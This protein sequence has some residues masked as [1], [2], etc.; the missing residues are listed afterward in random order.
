M[1]TYFAPAKRTE[2]RELKNQIADLSHNPIINALLK[3]TSGLL[4]VLNQDRQIV[5][6]NHAYIEKFGIKDIQEA[7]GLRLGESLACIHAFKKPDGCGTTEYC[8][9]CGAAIAIMSAFQDNITTEQICALVSDKGGTESDICLQVKAEPI[10]LEGQ[11]WLLFYAQDITQQQF[12]V[13]LDRVFFHDINNTLTALYGNVQLFEIGAPD[14]L[15]IISI[16]KS[17]ERL[18][19]EVAIQKNFSQHKDYSY[20]SVPTAVSLYDIKRELGLI[21]SGHSAS[22]H[23]KIIQHWTDK[24]LILETDSLLLSR[25]IGNMVINALEATPKGGSIQ[26]DVF[27]TQETITWE[28]SNKAFIPLPI[29]KR[30]FQRHFSS[31]SGGGR[32]L[33]T[34]SMKLFGETYLKG[35]ISFHSTLD[36]GTVF[37][38]CLPFHPI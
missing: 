30:I 35:K 38:F 36:H 25:I 21:I 27:N 22:F 13:N 15:E 14:N 20:T 23:K 19:N 16:R 11:R 24:D 29:Q 4:V 1:D 28:V 26:I 18:I 5:A 34:Y 2:K 9:T 31:K 7:L 37:R 12:W 3:T 8:S 6:L 10:E 32:G 17:I 33:G